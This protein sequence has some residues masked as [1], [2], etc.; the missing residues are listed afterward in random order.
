MQCSKSQNLFRYLNLIPKSYDK[1]LSQALLQARGKQ[2]NKNIAQNIHS[3]KDFPQILADC[4]KLS[5]ITQ[6]LA[7]NL[8]RTLFLLA[9]MATFSVIASVATQRVAI[10]NS[11]T[12]VIAKNLQLCQKA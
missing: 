11:T 2:G 3:N 10:Y 5:Q 12:S 9:M 8:L 1:S 7:Q 6:I 4:H